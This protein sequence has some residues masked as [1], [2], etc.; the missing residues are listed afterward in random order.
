[1]RLFD[2]LGFSWDRSA[3]PTG[4]PTSVDRSVFRYKQMF[5]QFVY[6][7]SAL[8]GNPFTFSEV[9]TL[10]DGV[11]VGGHKLSDE[12]QVLNLAKAAKELFVL[13]RTGTFRLEKA[14]FD[15]LHG[16]VAREEALEWGHFRGEGRHTDTT[17]RVG[18]GDGEFTPSHSTEPDAE[19]L[20]ALFA[21][22]VAELE[23]EVSDPRERAMAFFLFGSLH[24]FYFDGNKRTSRF[25]MN[26]VLMSHGMDA[27]SV[28]A[29][30]AQEFNEK[31]V[32]FYTSKDATEM[33][34]FLIDCEP[35]D[36]PKS[37]PR[38]TQIS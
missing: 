6:D 20:K 31:M 27:I 10:L 14:V 5:A 11:T 30:R 23:A 34:G 25:M 12:Q 9:K 19:N 16:L 15:R 1:M 35:K 7:A 18:I 26:G 17:P 29:V 32:R 37:K 4:V 3:I 22:G 36:A 38:T 33:M 28:P 8:E 13:V 2:K 21:Q 24:Q